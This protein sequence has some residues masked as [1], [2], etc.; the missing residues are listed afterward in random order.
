M[1]HIRH[2]L[3][4]LVLSTSSE[5][6]NQRTKPVIQ[7]LYEETKPVLDARATPGTEDNMF[8]FEGG[9]VIKEGGK[10]YYF[11]AELFRFPVDANMR[12]ALWRADQMSGPWHRIRT[13]QQ[14]NQSYP[15]A[16]FKQQCNQGYCAWQNASRERFRMYIEYVCDPNDLLGSPWAPF[17]IFDEVDNRWHVLYVS[18]MCDGT[19]MVSAGGGNIFGARS[20]AAGL[21]GIEGPYITYGVVIGPNASDPRKRWGSPMHSS[22]E[23]TD[24]IGPYL[25]PNGSFAAFVGEGSYLAFASRPVGPWHVTE[26]QTNAIS[27]PKSTYNE[28]PT[29]TK[30]SRPDGSMV[31]VA[32]FDTVYNEANGFGMTWSEDGVH[33]AAG[34]DV[35]L[36]GGCRTPLGLIDEGN[37]SA[38]MLFTRRFADCDNQTALPRNGADAISPASCA[39]VY[40]AAFTVSWATGDDDSVVL[41]FDAISEASMSS[42]FQRQREFRERLAVLDAERA[43]L[44]RLLGDSSAELASDPT[45]LIERVSI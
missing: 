42:R 38:K 37:G 26:S 19:W 6:I 34:V 43:E 35:A 20:V 10:Y 1:A 25:L 9:R 13:I 40:A 29:V 16:V 3:C 18:Y 24:S 32:V 33:W 36:P 27:T 45:A 17:P 41:D 39:N 8:G 14:S 4:A 44:L 30:L 31:L 15:Q 2:A 12:I 5:T 22:P 23:Y 7:F 21:Q 11:T 28:N